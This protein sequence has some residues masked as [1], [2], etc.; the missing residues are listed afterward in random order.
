MATR[1][2]SSS[3]VTAGAESKSKAEAYQV[4]SLDEETGDTIIKLVN[5]TGSDRVFAID[6]KNLVTDGTATVYQVAGDSL[7]NDN[8]L[9]A[10]EDCIMKEFTVEGISEQFNYTV[11][12]YS[13]TVIRIP[14]K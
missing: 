4:V 7:D 1:L 6:T 8:I 11:P 14:T 2:P 10:E 3:T 5:V 12:Q 9:G 13:A